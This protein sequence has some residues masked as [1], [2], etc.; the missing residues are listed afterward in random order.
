[1]RSY[2]LWTLKE[3]PGEEPVPR[4]V[5]GYR[6]YLLAIS[7]AWVRISCRSIIQ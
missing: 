5:Y 1:M 6:P 4:E 2:N 7:V 3:R